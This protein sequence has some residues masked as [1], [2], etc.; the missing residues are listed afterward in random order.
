MEPLLDQ[1][2]RALE[3]GL[4]RA[5]RDVGMSPAL[6]DKTLAALGMGAAGVAATVAVKSSSLTWFASKGAW[7]ATKGGAL[8]SVSAVATASVVTAMALSGGL[9]DSAEEQQATAH[10]NNGAPQL[11]TSPARDASARD[12]SA[13]DQAEP[14]ASQVAPVDAADRGA[15]DEMSG[16]GEPAQADAASRS[17]LKSQEKASRAEAPGQV[18]SVLREELS[19]IARVESALR[20]G[21]PA[22]A[23]KLLNEYRSRFPKPQ[24]GLE[25]E[26]LTIQAL[27]ESGSV[28]A[29]GKRAQG[30]LDRHPQ[31]PLGARARQYLK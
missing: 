28:A 12:A 19:Q 18:P 27:H 4:L 14:P 16:R 9:S 31:S 10:L 22:G 1:E 6:R 24:L 25:A 2:H 5:G 26:V 11:E 23:L 20:S 29:A 13:R 8:F 3:E 7:F 30:F 21:N 17:K 15:K